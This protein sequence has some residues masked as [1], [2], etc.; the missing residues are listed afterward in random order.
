MDLELSGP[1]PP[2]TALVH[3]FLVSMR[4]A[5][6]VFLE[7]CELFPDADVF[8]PVYDEEGTGGVLSHRRVHTS[9]LQ[10]LRPTASTFRA[11][12]PL[13]PAAIE[14]LDLRGYEL[15]VSSSSA[16]AHGVICDEDAVHVCYCHNP[17]RYAWNERR[18]TLDERRDPVTRAILAALFRR[19]R[20]WDSVAAQRVD[21]YLTNSQVTRSRIRAYFGRDAAVL[22]PPVDTSRFRPGRPGDEYIVLSELVSHKR[23]DEAVLAFNRL[24]LPLVVVGGGPD[25]RRLAAMAGPTVR[26]TGRIPDDEA[27][28]LLASSRALVVTA[29]EEFGLVAVEAQAAGRPVL[30]RRE[31]GALET[32][33]EGV[34]GRLWD[35][36]VEGLMQ[37]VESLD[38]DQIDPAR[39][40]ENASRFDSATFREGFLAAVDGALRDAEE[41]RRPVGES[42]DR[43][44]RR[45]AWLA[46][47][48][49]RGGG[50][51]Y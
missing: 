4:G 34:T 23:I 31:G 48:A 11:F 21:H 7:I 6:R 32:V 39:C 43:P 15:V 19:W 10:R 24:G 8:V 2:R 42:S 38:A 22:H 30:A 16:W 46:S 51:A 5:D 41:R 25:A 27:A 9:F 26:F 18:R 29:V 33:I 13:Y 36:G 28:R 20:V 40:V 44:A 45:R 35:G 50:R 3:D 47:A 49:G 14:S 1:A 37:A 12:L 17:F